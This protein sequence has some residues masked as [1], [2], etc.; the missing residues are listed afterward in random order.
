MHTYDMSANI[1]F[2]IADL[3]CIVYIQFVNISKCLSAVVSSVSSSQLI[4]IPHVVLLVYIYYMYRTQHF[5]CEHIVVDNNTWIIIC[6]L[7][8]NVQFC[9]LL[10]S[11]HTLMK[12]ELAILQYYTY[13]R[14]FGFTFFQ[15]GQNSHNIEHFLCYYSLTK[16]N[17]EKRLE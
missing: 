7:Q 4:S 16:L 14:I 11:L 2:E 9:F 3:S 12:N 1:K 13:A 6:K 15:W 10:P 5:V 17:K 8:H